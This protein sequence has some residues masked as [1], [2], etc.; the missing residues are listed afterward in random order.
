VKD[1]KMRSSVKSLKGNGKERKRIRMQRVTG[2]TVVAL[3]T[4]CAFAYTASAA[5]ISVVPAF[6]T[7]STGENFSVDIYVDPEG[8]EVVGAQ[9]KL[10]FNNTLLNATSLTLGT[11][12]NGFDTM[13]YGE[14]INNTFGN[15]TGRIDYGEAIF[16]IGDVGVTSP[17]TLTTI[18][19][20]AIAEEDGISELF[21]TTVKLSDPSAASIPTNITNGS[22]SVRT[23][24]C[25]D[26]NDDE[27]INMD[28]VMSLWYD[29][30]DYPNPGAYTISNA[31][32]ADVTCDGE[33]NMDDVMSLWYDYA[34]YPCPGAYVV[35][36]CN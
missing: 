22:V 17:G 14:G 2:L 13:P 3:I 12:F 33:I 34:D 16:P 36:C 23:G 5:H 1:E 35:N 25:G 28:D 19:F 29:Y 20:Q 6:Q 15:T 21:F 24:I 8:S 32:A 27:Q 26:V 10:Y 7:V 4:L 11:F 9:Y 18:T 31:W 30:A